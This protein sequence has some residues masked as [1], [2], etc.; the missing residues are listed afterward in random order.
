MFSWQFIFWSLIY[1]E[2][3]IDRVFIKKDHCKLGIRY[4]ITS[5]KYRI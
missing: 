1:G 3:L 5:F 4:G 2:Y